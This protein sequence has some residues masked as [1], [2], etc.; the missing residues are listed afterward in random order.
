MSN[1]YPIAN[2]FELQDLLGRGGMGEVYHATDTQAGKTVAVKTL[3]PEILSNDPA[4]LERFVREGEALRRLNHT[5][6]S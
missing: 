6:L 1:K 4:L 5:N 3:N 2:R